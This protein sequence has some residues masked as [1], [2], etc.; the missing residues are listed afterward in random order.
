[1][2]TLFTANLKE[3]C[4]A[5]RFGTTCLRTIVYQA[6]V[7]TSRAR[8]ALIVEECGALLGLEKVMEMEEPEGQD[9][10]ALDV[11]SR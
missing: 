5:F 9:Q 2:E 1:M 3:W 8:A 10:A 4:L 6:S 7:S 11:E